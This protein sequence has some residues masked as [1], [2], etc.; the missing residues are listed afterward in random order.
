MN[1]AKRTAVMADDS[2]LVF[3]T[4]KEFKQML[5]LYEDLK[6]AQED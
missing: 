3:S 5:Y 6:S 4:S 1:S 2:E